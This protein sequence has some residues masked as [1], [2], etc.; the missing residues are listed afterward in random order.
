[1]LHLRP[2]AASRTAEWR[3]A[4]RLRLQVAAAICTL[5]A[6]SGDGAQ[7]RQADAWLNSF[8]STRAAWD[9][10]LA[11]LSHP[12]VEVRAA[13]GGLGVANRQQAQG[14]D[15]CIAASPAQRTRLAQRARPT[16]APVQITPAR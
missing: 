2:R 7:Q 9:V 6:A 4:T 5:L 12:Q 13:E 3:R 11:L 16:A 1:V 10:S 15:A 14:C 8:S